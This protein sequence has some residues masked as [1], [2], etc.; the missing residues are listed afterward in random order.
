[1]FLAPETILEE[2]VGCAVD[3]WATGVIL[4]LMLVGYPPFWSSS[5]EFLLLSIL[6]GR[7]TMPSPYWDNIKS[8][9]K[10]LVS[11][12]IVKQPESRLTATQSLAHPA[13]SDSA[14]GRKASVEKEVKR[15][16]L[17]VARG[18]RAL[19]KFKKA[20]VKSASR[21]LSERGADFKSPHTCLQQY[22]EPDSVFHF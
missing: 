14:L 5:D 15:N 12:L 4:Y 16:F 7:Y 20:N 19:V 13:L 18:I 10:D 2:P 8:Q 9:T 17:A 22:H 21:R 11:K 3:M 6:E 1:M